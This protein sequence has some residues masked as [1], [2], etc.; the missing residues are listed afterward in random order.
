MQEKPNIGHVTLSPAESGQINV[1]KTIFFHFLRQSL[2]S[3]RTNI[4][5]TGSPPIRVCH[6][7]KAL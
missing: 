1:R 7:K 2:Y 3:K 4:W 6:I 5:C